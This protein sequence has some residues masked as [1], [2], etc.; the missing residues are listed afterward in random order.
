M[1]CL[2][3]AIYQDLLRQS[4]SNLFVD[5]FLKCIFGDHQSTKDLGQ[6]KMALCKPLHKWLRI[7]LR[8]HQSLSIL[9]PRSGLESALTLSGLGGGATCARAFF[10]RLLF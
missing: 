7:A 3:P 6:K 2:L 10:K 1:F 8:S 9:D 4:A 5:C